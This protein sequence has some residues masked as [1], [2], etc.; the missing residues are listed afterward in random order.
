MSDDKVE[1][2]VLDAANPIELGLDLLLGG[3]R[4][5]AQE[6]SLADMWH[7]V[8]DAYF[9]GDDNA[10]DLYRQALRILESLEDVDRGEE[11]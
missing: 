4:L 10:Q 8:A 5:L 1:A 2:T 9:L 7:A 11:Q 6:A 3:I